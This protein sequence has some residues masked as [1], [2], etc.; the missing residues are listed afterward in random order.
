MWGHIQSSLYERAVVG[1][2]AAGDTVFIYTTAPVI[3]TCRTVVLSSSV[4]FPAASCSR[5]E[6]KNITYMAITVCYKAWTK[7]GVAGGQHISSLSR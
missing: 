2:E 4:L 6:I 1:C 3:T 5:R 7:V